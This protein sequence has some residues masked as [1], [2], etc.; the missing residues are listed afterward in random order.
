M[1]NNDK[2]SLQH[3]QK[4]YYNKDFPGQK[5]N[6]PGLHGKMSPV[7]DSGEESYEGHGRLQGRK[8]LITGGDSGIGRAIA[9]AFAREGADVVINYLPEE[10]ED[11]DSLADL[12][13]KENIKLYML[14]G[15]LRDENTCIK[16]V[17]DAKKILDGLDIVVLNAGVQV[18]QT[19]IA[20]LTSEQI[21]KTFEVN[22]YSVMYMAREAVAVMPEGSSIIVTA[23]AEYYTPNKMLLDYAASKSAVVGFSVG[24]AKQVIDK[25]IRVNAVCPGPVWTPLEISGGIPDKN[26]PQHGKDTPLKRSGQPVEMAGIYVFLASNESSYVTGEIF[27]LTGG[28]SGR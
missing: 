14:P 15:D 7:P 1:E 8:A 20:D 5:Q 27:G 3:P 25:G 28:L 18:A 4:M 17:H 19:D 13:D 23:S 26:I 21:K 10:Q 16:V 2:N 24:L 6:P 12:L 11:A 9:I 22:V